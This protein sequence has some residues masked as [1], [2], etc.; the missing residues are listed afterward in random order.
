LLITH[1]YCLVFFFDNIRAVVFHLSEL[2]T[3][4]F[5]L[6]ERI[7]NEVPIFVSS[8]FEEMFNLCVDPNLVVSHLN[9]AHFTYIS[10]ERL[11]SSLR[12]C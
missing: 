3:G 8:H 9:G 5:L 1:S 10:I 6:L 2:I 11:L 12:I 7:L 4:A